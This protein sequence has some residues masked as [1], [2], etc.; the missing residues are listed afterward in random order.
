[1]TA[2]TSLAVLIAER[3]EATPSVAASDEAAGDDVLGE[4]TGLSEG[5]LG[6]WALQTLHPEMSTY[7]VPLAFRIAHADPVA[8]QGAF[9]AVLTRYPILGRRFEIVD[10]EP[11]LAARFSERADAGMS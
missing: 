2:W 11:R 10:G 4:K 7:N 3:C 9:G 5:Q 6:L 8:L 1:M